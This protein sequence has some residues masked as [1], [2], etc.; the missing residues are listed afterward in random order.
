MEELHRLK[1]ILHDIGYLQIY[2]S[3]YL[4]NTGKEDTFETIKQ[5]INNNFDVWFR[6]GSRM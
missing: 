1:K 6:N 3:M 5:Y 4:P 2:L